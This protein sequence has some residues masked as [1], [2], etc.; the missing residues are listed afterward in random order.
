MSPPFP[1]VEPPF[2]PRVEV[3]EV[4]WRRGPLRE[5]PAGRL[6][7][8]LT[9]ARGGLFVLLFALPAPSEPP[10]SPVSPREKLRHRE[11]TRSRVAQPE[12]S[13]SGRHS[14]IRPRSRAVPSEAAR[15]KGRRRQ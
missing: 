7:G 12:A 9:G 8:S 15:T 5:K 10:W 1:L 13:A 6:D 14:Q 3:P 2:A 4:R 11:A